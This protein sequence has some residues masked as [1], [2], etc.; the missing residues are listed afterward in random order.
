MS[1]SVRRAV[2]GPFL[3]K[4]LLPILALLLIVVFSL[5]LPATFPTSLTARS[6]LDSQAIIAM[7]AL[8][9]MLVVIVGEY[10]L[11]VGYMCGLIN[12]LTIGFIVKNGLPFGVT[13]VLVLVIGAG[14]GFANGAL[15]YFFK[16]DS[17]IATLGT[18]TLAYAAANWYTQGQQVFGKLPASLTDI[19]STR[20]LG[21]P[22]AAV[23]V[24][25]GRVKFSV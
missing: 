22:F 1:R 10:D 21:I 16:I 6:I 7:L 3:A 20:A 9:E 12:I 23:I 15:V 13:A 17:F 11:S 14:L 25:V 2:S 24:V 5:L 18:G 8:A 4:Y 19:Y